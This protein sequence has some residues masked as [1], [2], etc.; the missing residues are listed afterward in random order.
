M[1]IQFTIP[2]S[3]HLGLH[4]IVGRVVRSIG[5]R[6]ATTQNQ[7][8]QVEAP[9]ERDM[10]GGY[11][12]IL[13]AAAVTLLYG[14]GMPMLYFVAA[15]GFGLRYWAE[16]YCDLRIFRRPPLYSRELV[17]SFDEARRTRAFFWSTF[18]LILS[19]KRIVVLPR[20]A[21]DTRWA[22]TQQNTPPVFLQVLSLLMVIHTAMSA[23]LIGAAGGDNPVANT[24]TLATA[25][26]RPHALPMVLCFPVVLCC[27]LFK[28]LARTPLRKRLLDWPLTRRCLDDDRKVRE[29]ETP[30]M[31]MCLNAFSVKI[32]YLI[33]Q[34]RLRISA[35]ETQNDRFVEPHRCLT[36]SSRVSAPRTRKGCSGT[37]TTTTIWI[38]WRCCA[39][40]K[41][42]SLQSWRSSTILSVGRAMTTTIAAA[43]HRWR[44]RPRRCK[45][46]CVQR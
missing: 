3:T 18:D 5:R 9:V 17:G 14:P 36:R 10:A 20:Q 19:L 1:M 42:C 43:L 24:I 38:S 22:S 39:T 35:R 32:D 15:A 33:C 7:L 30:F 11:G 46:G 16:L 23:Y 2:C 37:R 6:R 31:S 29:R 4:H 40:S 44:G 21:W 27:F 45:S 28:L 8:N 26:K 12:E 13:L 25:L 41:S 34:D